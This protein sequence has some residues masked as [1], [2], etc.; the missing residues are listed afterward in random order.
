M[1]LGCSGTW[2]HC[3][4]SFILWIQCVHLILESLPPLPR[5]HSAAIGCTKKLPANR[6]DLHSHCVE[7]F[8]GLYS[9]VAEGGVAGNFEKTQFF[10]NT[11]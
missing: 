8:D 7:S 3:H 1:L 5:Q 11:L 2:H 6:S 10:L 4:M 9:D